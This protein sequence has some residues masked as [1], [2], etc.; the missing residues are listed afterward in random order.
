MILSL[1]RKHLNMM[2]HSK[3]V[4]NTAQADLYI[5]MVIFTKEDIQKIR[6][7]EQV[8]YYLQMADSTKACLQM[9]S[10][11]EKLSINLRQEMHLLS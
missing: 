2:V 1:G 10:S 11:R 4:S 3:T 5:Q 9:I 7:M 6:G 8:P